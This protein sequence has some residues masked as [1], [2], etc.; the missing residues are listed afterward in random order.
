MR[1]HTQRLPALRHQFIARG[2]PLLQCDRK[3]LRGNSKRLM[4]AI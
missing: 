4:L 2:D 3:Y 1:Q